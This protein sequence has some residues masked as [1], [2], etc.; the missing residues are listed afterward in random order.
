MTSPDL[1]RLHIECERFRHALISADKRF[2]PITLRDFPFGACGDAT[3]LLAK[4][5]DQQGFGLFDYML[6]NRGEHSHA[7]LQRGELIVDITADQFPDVVE[8][9]IVTTNSPWH[10]TFQGE[11]EN[12]A[13]Y[14]IYDQR[15]RAVLGMAY[16]TILATVAR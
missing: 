14:E 9:I 13:D 11:P 1:Q 8:T 15:T 2:L 10:L 16:T 12:V 3:L 6:G 5:L 4:Y 7:W